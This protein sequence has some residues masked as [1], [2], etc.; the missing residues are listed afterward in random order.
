VQ[1]A[2]LFS[3]LWIGVQLGSK[4]RSKLGLQRYFYR[5]WWMVGM[6]RDKRHRGDLPTKGRHEG[7]VLGRLRLGWAKLGNEKWWAN[8]SSDEAG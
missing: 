8:G 7:D 1:A 3:R 5:S 2:Y 6:G 4:R